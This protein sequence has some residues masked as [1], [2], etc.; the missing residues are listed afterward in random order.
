MGTSVSPCLED[1]DAA[2][3]VR[4]VDLHLAVE[5]AG[6]E[7]GGVQDVGAV[8]R[9]HHDDAGV[10]LEAV[11]LG[12]KLVEGLLAL[13]VATADAGAT[14]AAHRVD[15]VDED[16]ARSVLLGLLAGPYTRPLL[17]ST[18][19]VTDTRKHPTSPLR[20]P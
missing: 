12:E 14:A 4:H 15:L 3:D 18:E 20:P 11:H 5:A 10:A 1:L 8:G 6:A 19:A 13:V 17:S 7:Q 9:R 16:D 2:L